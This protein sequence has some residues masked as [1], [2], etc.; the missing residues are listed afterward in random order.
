MSKK[1][2]VIVPSRGTTCIEWTFAFRN[3]ELP[4]G[5]DAGYVYGYS[6]DHERNQAVAAALR[7]GYEWLFFIDDDVIMPPGTFAKLASHN[8]DIVSGLYWKRWEP[9]EPAMR[10]DDG[11]EHRFR[12]GDLVEVDF[13]GAGC[14]LIRRN[15]LEKMEYPWFEWATSRPDLP[16]RERDSDDYFFCRK[17][18]KA[19]FKV[20]VDTG[21]R[22]LHVGYGRAGFG[23]VFAPLRDIREGADFGIEV[24]SKLAEKGAVS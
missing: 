11:K 21:V 12:M 9:I 7:G 10:W 2:L 1:V 6:V 18:R 17:A 23:N 19:G 5:S 4:E 22:C 15:V 3:L 16:Q 8:L 14:L 24:V 20:H 13:A